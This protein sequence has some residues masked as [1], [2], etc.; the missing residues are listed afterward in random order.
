MVPV[1]LTNIFLRVFDWGVLQYRTP[2]K[3]QERWSRLGFLF[4]KG[5]RVLHQL[6]VRRISNFL[7]FRTNLGLCLSYCSFSLLTR[8]PVP[9]LAHKLP[10]RKK[11]KLNPGVWCARKKEE[12]EPQS[13]TCPNCKHTRGLRRRSGKNTAVKT[14]TLVGVIKRNVCTLIWIPSGHYIDAQSH[15]YIYITG[16]H[17]K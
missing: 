2:T 3:K 4:E 13:P 17:S 8:C 16:D 12:I 5:W 1:N 10:P 7:F 6:Q 14:Y 15:I 11:R 9:P